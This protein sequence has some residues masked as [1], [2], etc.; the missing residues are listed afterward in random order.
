M[1]KVNQLVNFFEDAIKQ[2]RFKPNQKLMSIR[3]A[4]DFFNVSKNTVVD[5]Y[6]RLVSSG[7]IRAKPGSGYFVNYPVNRIISQEKSHPRIRQALDSASL[8]KEQINPTLNIRV[9]D[10]RPPVQWIDQIDFDM[11]IKIP[12]NSK[13]SYTPPMGFL[14]LREVFSQHLYERNIQASPCQIITTYG[15]NHAM[16]LII[17]NFLSAGDT[18]FVDSPGYYPLFAKLRLYNIRYIG[19]NRLTTGPD[20]EELEEKAIQYR[21]KL[22][23][24]QTLGH[25][26]TGGAI[27][28]P[29]QYQILKIAEKFN[30]Y[31]VEND[32]FADLSPANSPRMS[33]LDQLD[34][35][36]YIGT[37]SKT[38]SANFRIGFIAGSEKIINSIANIKMLTIVNSSDYLERWLHNIMTNGQY[39]R[40]IRRLRSLVED[41]TQRAVHQFTQLGLHIP[42]RSEGSYYVWV[43]LRAQNDVDIAQKAADRSIFLAPGS[44]FYPDKKGNHPAALRVNVAY[45]LAPEFLDFLQQ[46][47]AE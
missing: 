47:Q 5:A 10:G 13:F 44:L 45:A 1:N 43:E 23:F 17:K 46:I 38:L 8:L 6:D 36:I 34:R 28:I 16:D 27:N 2:E 12:T 20:I 33:A 37:Y 40:H 25:N 15:A 26:P 18:V 11:R 30:F 35:V 14:P 19:I 32:A 7:V 42:F 9:G 24:T 21:P 4:S 31:C 41:S 29:T 22:F 3:A 39:L